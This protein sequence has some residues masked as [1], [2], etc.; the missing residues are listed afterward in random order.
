MSKMKVTAGPFVF[1]GRLEID[2]APKT[3]AAF[4][5]RAPFESNVVHVR[6]SGEGVW[7]PLGDYKFD[8]DYSIPAGSARRRSCSPTAACVSPP[9]SDSLRA[10][11]SSR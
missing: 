2:L 11:T 8:V 10:T 7:M 5:A 3:C 4:L 6:W 1:E 9:R